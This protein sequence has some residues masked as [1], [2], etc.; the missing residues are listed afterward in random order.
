MKMQRSTQKDIHSSIGNVLVI[1]LEVDSWQSLYNTHSF[2][3]LSHNVQP[4]TGNYNSWLL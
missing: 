1:D 2:Y 4:E 3:H